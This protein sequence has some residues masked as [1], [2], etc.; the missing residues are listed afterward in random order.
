MQPVSWWTHCLFLLTASHPS[1]R[2]LR[3]SIQRTQPSPRLP[4]LPQSQPHL[5][6]RHFVH[7]NGHISMRPRLI[8][9]P[10]PSPSHGPSHPDSPLTTTTTPLTHPTLPNIRDMVPIYHPKTGP[11]HPPR[12]LVTRN[13]K[14]VVPIVPAHT[15]YRIRIPVRVDGCL[16]FLHPKWFFTKNNNP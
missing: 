5:R 2:R 3:W 6:I 14:P 9:R 15:P 16:A 8:L 4:V 11:V 7:C 10:S 12:T 13:R 1:H